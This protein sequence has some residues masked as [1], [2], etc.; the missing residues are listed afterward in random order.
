M[1]LDERWVDRT[2]EQMLGESLAE[3]AERLEMVVED[4]TTLSADRVI[5][6]GFGLLPEPVAPLLGDRS[7]AIFLLPTPGFR[8]WAL[9]QR[10]WHTVGGTSDPDRAR[11]NKLARDSLLTEHV[12]TTATQLGLGRIDVDGT[13]PLVEVTAD[14]AA[15]LGLI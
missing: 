2:P 6:D 10:G 7:Q 9:A 11:A 3:F 14:V 5:A 13:R 15:Q 4:I 1:S 8:E 12:R